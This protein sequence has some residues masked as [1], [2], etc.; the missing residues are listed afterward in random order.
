MVV[1][2]SQP[3]AVVQSDGMLDWAVAHSHDVKFHVGAELA[4]RY[5]GTTSGGNSPAW[6]G[7][8]AL[9]SGSECQFW[10]LPV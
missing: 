9:M 3:H 6:F 5:R 10:I 2:P 4:A 7:F 8:R 1:G